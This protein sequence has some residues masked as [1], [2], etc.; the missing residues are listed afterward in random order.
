MNRICVFCG[1][2]T[3]NSPLFLEAAVQLGRVLAERGLELVYGG[4]SIGL[5][6][7]VADSVMA[8][9]GKVVGVIPE[10]MA[11]KEVAHD[12]LTEM[13]V[14]SSMHERKSMMARLADAFVALPGG[15]GSFEELLEM[16]TWAQLGIH[17]KP[18]GI[19]NVSGYYDPLIQLFEGAIEAGFI[20]PRNR[21]LYVIEREADRL[22]RTLLAH[23]L[24]EVKR[25]IAERE[26]W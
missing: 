17:R 12:G 5:M 19:L 18:V 23:K 11:S 14:V 4:A 6:G 13:H 20:K 26:T 7:A 10:A 9:G 24:P 8:G 25:W 16:I 22:L 15:F 1:S 3:G 2:K 21:Q